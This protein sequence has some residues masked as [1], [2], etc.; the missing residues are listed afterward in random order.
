MEISTTVAIASRSLVSFDRRKTLPGAIFPD[1]FS[2]VVM[3][4]FNEPAG[5]SASGSL[6]TGS[7]ATGLGL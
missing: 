2:T 6:I 3:N 5:S 1:I 4:N 7:S